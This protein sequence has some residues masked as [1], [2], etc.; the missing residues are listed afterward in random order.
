ME[1]RCASVCS[2]KILVIISV[3]NIKIAIF[4]LNAGREA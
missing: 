1:Q 4:P 3:D 2:E